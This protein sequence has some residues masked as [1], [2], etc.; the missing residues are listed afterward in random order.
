M[1]YMGITLATIFTMLRLANEAKMCQVICSGACLTWACGS[2]LNQREK[3]GEE[4][5]K[6]LLSEKLVCIPVVALLSL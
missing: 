1:P 6:G 4:G 2:S 3:G 5:N